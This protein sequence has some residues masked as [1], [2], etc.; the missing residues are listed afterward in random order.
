VRFDKFSNL[1][2]KALRSIVPQ[3]ERGLRYDEACLE[4]GYHHSQLQPADAEK[5]PYL[6]PFYS[7]RDSAGRM[8]FNE[9][10][11]IPRNP[12]V[13]RALNQSRKVVNALIREYGAPHSVHIEMARDLSRPAEER[14]K[15][16]DAQEEFR[17][18]NDKDKEN[19]VSQFNI[20]G[21]IDGKDFDKYQL[22]REQQG[23]C[24]YPTMDEKQGICAYSLQPLDINRLLEAGY[25]EIDHVLPYAR[26]FD[27]SKNN[28]VLVLTRENRNKAD[29]TP[30]EY[31]D[32]A[33]NSARWREFVAFVE[34]N[35]LYRQAKRNRLLKKD[36]NDKDA[37]G[38]RERNLNDTRYICRFF[39]N[40]VEQ[41][42]QLH[43]D[44]TA[45]RCV[46]LSGSLTSLLRARWGL[47]KVRGENDRHHALDAVVIAA[48]GHQVVQ[49]LSTLVNA[50]GWAHKPEMGG[51]VQVDTG[52]FLFTRDFVNRDEVYRLFPR[53]WRHFRDELVA[54]LN[55]DDPEQL[56][57][58]AMQFGTYPPAA[59]EN[60]HPL[61][62]S[63]APQRRNGGEIHEQTIR[64]AKQ[65]DQNKSCVKTELHK[66][67]LK[68]LE[69]IVGATYSR[70]AALIAL[71]RQ[72][73]ESN[74]NDGKKAF[75]EP[76]YKPSV[77]G[78]GSLVRAIKL[79][80]TQKG[81][82]LMRGGLADLGKMKHVDVYSHHKGFL[83]APAYTA[84]E[85]KRI[86][87]P[88]V[89]VDALFLFSLN[90]NDYVKITLGGVQFQGYF[91]MYESDGRVTL[92][93][94]DQSKP[95]KSY[96]RKAISNMTNIEKFNVDVLGNIYPA[97]AE[98]RRDLA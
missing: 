92:R 63:R 56:R 91:V 81:G 48:C 87:V 76:V 22:Y 88:P 39:K 29:Q 86:R 18:R 67:K 75:A 70:N 42:L 60:L 84:T 25:V 37:A 62:V 80:T 57:T 28:K 17:E 97:P 41:Y 11:D 3:M 83:V 89:P 16:K 65:I 8:V 6:P 45:K 46:V 55:L 7:G 2:L 40:Y 73:L 35:K 54:R 82:M 71:L 69:N 9:D 23:K 74:D 51:Y 90:K 85:E 50:A 79:A 38:F 30:Y 52:E 31:L 78:K 64:S 10:M 24:I 49:R 96:F 58:A 95:D 1:S 77:S 14:K 21:K 44:S 61:F 4:A 5:H 13:L 43:T 33:N 32:G 66:L 93:A 94:H 12:V 20:I 53:P 19:F 72:R 27:D 68:D 34:S 47:V 26:S 36:F 59:I 15:V 98:S